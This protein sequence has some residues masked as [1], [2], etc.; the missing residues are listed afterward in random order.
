MPEGAK[1]IFHNGVSDQEYEELLGECTAL[2]TLSREEGYG[3]PLVEAMSMGTP[4]VATDM[5]IFREVADDAAL[6]AAPD[7]PRGFAEQVRRLA[8]HETWSRYSRLAV[9]RAE[10]YSWERSARQLIELAEYA[11]NHRAKLRGSAGKAFRS[12]R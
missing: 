7:D 11:S 10:N 6:F 9:L 1:V 12:K 5:P 8:D 2:V 3:L 4:V